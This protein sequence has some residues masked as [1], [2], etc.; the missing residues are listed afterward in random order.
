MI[1]LFKD[2]EFYTDTHEDGCIFITVFCNKIICLMIIPCGAVRKSTSSLSLLLIFC[3]YV[4]FQGL[5]KFII[6][7]S[8]VYFAEYFI[9]QGLVS[10]FC[11]SHRQVKKSKTPVKT[12]CDL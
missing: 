11:N 8:V 4:L 12:T 7:L 1:Y 10:V 3:L 9:N 6:P 5:L 2:L